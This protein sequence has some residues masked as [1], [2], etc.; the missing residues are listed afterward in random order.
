MSVK[1]KYRVWN[2]FIQI[3]KGRILLKSALL[4]FE[5]N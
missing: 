1:T 3:V 2:Y 4:Q 5:P